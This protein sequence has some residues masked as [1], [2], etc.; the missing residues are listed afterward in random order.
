MNFRQWVFSITFSLLLLFPVTAAAQHKHGSQTKP[1]S[2]GMDMAM[3]QSP[4]HK[5]MMAYVASMSAFASALNEQAMKSQTLD[6]EAARATVAE[7]R[8][9]L[10]AMEALHQKHMQMMTAEMQTKMQTMMQDMDKN[11]EMLKEH[12]TAL[13]TAVQAEKPDATQV[14]THTTALVNQLQRMSKMHGS[15]SKKTTSMKM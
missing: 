2:P 13:E 12:V 5:L 1:A 7:L 9:N 4:H 8:H 15:K 11:R 14:R 10:D 3:M 6:A